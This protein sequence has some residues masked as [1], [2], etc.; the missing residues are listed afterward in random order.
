MDSTAYDNLPS[1]TPDDVLK[2]Q[3]EVV[4]AMTYSERL[5]LVCGMADLGY[6]QTMNMLKRR[7]NTSDETTLKIAFVETV[8]KNDF[9][10]EEFERIRDFF[11]KQKSANSF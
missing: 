2:K 6:K 5:R 4:Q 8:Y 10:R 9:S 11:N 7:L 1:D 3:I